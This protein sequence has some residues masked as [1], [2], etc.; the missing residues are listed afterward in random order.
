MMTDR[1]ATLRAF[2][3]RY[4][5]ERG[6]VRDPRIEQAF[7]AVPRESY[8]GPAPWSV[9][10]VRPW[11]SGHTGPSYIQTPDDDPAYLYQ[12]VLIAL[13]SARGINIGEPGLHAHCVDALAV[14]ENEAVLHVGA[15]AVT[16]PRFLPIWSGRAATSTRSRSTL[17]WRLAPR[18]TSGNFRGCRCKRVPGS[19]KICP[20]WMRFMSTPGSPSQAGRG[21]M[22]CGRGAGCCS[23]CSPKM[24]SRACC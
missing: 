8:A 10:I 18:I 20:R 9:L 16:T 3:A 2:F 13:D 15:A 21:S 7:A 4:V 24:V 5:T 6:G 1:S 23:R 11:S 14:A 22:P 19:P 17:T 12:D